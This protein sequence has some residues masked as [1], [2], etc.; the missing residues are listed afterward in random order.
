M[1]RGVVFTS[2][3]R[4]WLRLVAPNWREVQSNPFF[5]SALVEEGGFHY[6]FRFDTDK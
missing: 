2:H 1:S 4:R 5:S 6:L 3:A